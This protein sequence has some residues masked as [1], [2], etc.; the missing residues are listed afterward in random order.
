[1]HVRIGSGQ[2]PTCNTMN[3]SETYMGYQAQVTYQHVKLGSGQRPACDTKIRLE[4]S[5]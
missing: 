4:T 1:M 2:R 5:M 3:R